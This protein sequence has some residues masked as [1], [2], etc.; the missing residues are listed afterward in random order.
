[1]PSLSLS[2]AA[3]AA[4]AALKSSSARL[5][6][7]THLLLQLLL[8]HL[9]E[10]PATSLA[11]S[12]SRAA[13]CVVIP[14]LSRVGVVPGERQ[15]LEAHLLCIAL[16]VVDAAMA[17]ISPGTAMPYLIAVRE[18]LALLASACQLRLVMEFA[19]VEKKFAAT[20]VAT[21]MSVGDGGSLIGEAPFIGVALVVLIYGVW[22]GY[23]SE[24]KLRY[25]TT[26]P[27]DDVHPDQRCTSIP[28]YPFRQQE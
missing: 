15:D 24:R 7:L 25:G 2:E 6:L 5:K 11:G 22:V 21:L 18:T 16:V 19:S 8:S 20:L 1:M 17:V 12:A 14:L 23:R 10:A 13:S 9:R 3:F 4:A 26:S 27:Q 28:Q